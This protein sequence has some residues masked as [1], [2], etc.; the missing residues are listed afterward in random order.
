MSYDELILFTKKWLE[1]W[2]GNRASLVLSFYSDDAFYRDPAMAAGISGKLN[3]GAYLEKLLRKNPEWVWEMVELYPTEL[4]FVLKWKATIPTPDEV[5]TEFG[6]DIVELK[7]GKITRNEVY[8]D[9]TK[10]SSK[11]LSR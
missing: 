1:S 5:I 6:M 4:G 9:A 7:D 11:R 3:L 2:S 10:L 8:F